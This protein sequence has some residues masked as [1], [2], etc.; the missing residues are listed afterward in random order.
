[1]FKVFSE[2]LSNLTDIHTQEK[3]YWNMILEFQEQNWSH[4]ATGLN[5]LWNVAVPDQEPKRTEMNLCTAKRPL[6]Q[7]NLAMAAPHTLGTTWFPAWMPL[8]PSWLH[9]APLLRA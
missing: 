9:K 4:T 6:L 2:Q 3:A 5:K 7:P 1:M 8:L